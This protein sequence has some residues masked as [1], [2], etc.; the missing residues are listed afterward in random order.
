MDLEKFIQHLPEQYVNWGQGNIQPKS[1]QFQHILDR[2][3]GMT[4]INIMQLLNFAVELLPA[5]EIFCEIGCLQGAN[6]I[7]ALINHPHVSAYAIDNFS[8]FD[9]FEQNLEQLIANLEAFDLTERVLFYQQNFE[10]F[11]SDL[12]NNYLENKIGLYVYDAAHDYRSQLMGLMLAKPFLA[13]QALIVITNSNFEASCQAVQ[14]FIHSE[15]QCQLIFDFANSDHYRAW[16]GTHILGWN[17][18]RTALELALSP[19]P[20]VTR[21]I[22]DLYSSQRQEFVEALHKEAIALHQKKRWLEAEKMYQQFLLW[23]GD[24]AVAWSNLGTLYYEMGSYEQA[25]QAL[26][27][28]LEIDSSRTEAHY[29]IGQVSER[30]GNF[31]QAIAAYQQAINLDSQNI[32]A[33]NNLGN[34]LVAVGNAKQAINIYQQAIAINPTHYGSYLNL[35]NVLLQ[36]QQLDQAI[37]AYEKALQ[38]KP[39]TS[40]VLYNLGVAYANKGD[41]AEAH[42]NFAHSFYREQ[43]YEEA[44]AEFHEFLALKTGS[45][46]VYCNFH[47]CLV[48][49][50]REAEALDILHTTIELYPDQTHLYTRLSKTLLHCGRSEE[51]LAVSQQAALAYPKDLELYFHAALLLP[52]FYQNTDEI[53]LWRQRFTIGLQNIISKVSLDT[54]AERQAALTAISR[55]VNFLLY[56]QGQNDVE[57]QS[58]YGQLVHGIMAAIYPQWTQPLNMPAISSDRKIRIGYISYNMCAH[59]GTSWALGWLKHCN[60]DLF[61]V[62]GYHIGT[63]LDATTQ[64]FRLYFDQFRHFPDDLESVCRSILDDQLHILV[65]LDIGMHPLATKIAALRLAPVQC[66][67]WGHPLTSGIPTIDYYL[68]GELTEPENGQEHYTEKLI[69]LPNIAISYPHPAVPENLSK[70]RIDFNFQTH[71]VIYLCCQMWCKYLPQYDYLFA[72]IAQQVPNAKFV[73]VEPDYKPNLS[74]R[75]GFRERLQPNFTALNLAVSD[76]IQFLPRLTNYDDY[77]SLLRNADVFLDTIGFSGGHTTLEA[78]AS[79]L[80]VVTL[81]GEFMRGRQSYGFLSLL[82][83]TETIATS[84]AEYIEIAIKLGL[85]SPWRTEIK[86]KMKEQEHNLYDDRVCVTG[87]E[88]FYQQVVTQYQRLSD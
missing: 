79:N 24:R 19:N 77:M 73:F 88:A 52:P 17:L 32:D 27:T 51:A 8:E 85:R 40:E 49:T 54:E 87:L 37:T 30:I 57:L 55:D 3:K 46:Y 6:L 59:A 66:T 12:R 81:P 21:S 23:Q 25:L 63:R 5:R 83:V 58:Q 70:T 64:V 56:Y 28:S 22:Y 68:T 47:E 2:F 38:L 76:Y 16:Q 18:D 13:E 9:P 35:G 84:E 75:E 42:L 4:T 14:D 31:P 26:I 7:A 20:S 41:I 65:F 74:I 71:E 48:K 60:K 86:Q 69:R 82:G 50:N 39:Y 45:I 80:P 62:Y 11:F 67:T 29:S 72:A 61:E 43:K 44:I 36:Q 78:I 1:P 15:P 33:Y 53:T 10:E 34:V